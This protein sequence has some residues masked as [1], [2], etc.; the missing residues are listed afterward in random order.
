LSNNISNFTTTVGVGADLQLTMA[1]PS[2]VARG[3]RLTYTFTLTNNGLSVAND[4]SL[5]S[6]VPT[7]LVFGGNSGDCSSAFPCAFGTLQPGD[8]KTVTT[9]ACVPA[10]YSGSLLIMSSG[11]ATTSSTDPNLSNNTASAYTSLIYDVLFTDGF[12]TCP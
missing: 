6:T 2:T 5:A 1:A 12:E 3:S 10:D 11:S 8:T 9:T 7:G 4:V